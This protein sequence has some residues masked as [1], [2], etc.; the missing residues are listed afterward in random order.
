MAVASSEAAKELARARWGSQRLDRLAAELVE[1]RAELDPD[2]RDRLARALVDEP[3][4][5]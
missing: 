3:K 4:G 5:N 2:E 1:R